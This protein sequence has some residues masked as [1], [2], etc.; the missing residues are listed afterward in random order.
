MKC[1]I[2]YKLLLDDIHVTITEGRGCVAEGTDKK[3]KKK[4]EN[5]KK[6]VDLRGGMYCS[7]LF[8]LV[9]P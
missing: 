3:K 1:R 4:K 5:A 7:K 2:R 8:G 6:E 9:Q